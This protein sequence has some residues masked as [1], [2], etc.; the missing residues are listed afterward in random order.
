MGCLFSRFLGA[1]HLLEGVEGQID[2]RGQPPVTIFC[3]NF[4]GL[5]YLEGTLEL[6][7]FKGV[8]VSLLSDLGNGS[9][10]TGV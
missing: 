4:H 1:P 9:T 6:F 3:E 10:V 2:G 5:S 7:H 8:K